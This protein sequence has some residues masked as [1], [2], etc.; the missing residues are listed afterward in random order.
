MKQPKFKIGQPLYFMKD[1]RVRCQTVIQ[2]KFNK[3][4]IYIYD[5]VEYLTNYHRGQITDCTKNLTESQVYTSKEE[6]LNS[7]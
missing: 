3:A 2:I 5:T 4:G 6:L 1:N 7:L